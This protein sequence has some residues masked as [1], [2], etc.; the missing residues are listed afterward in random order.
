[1]FEELGTLEEDVLKRDIAVEHA[2]ST[3]VDENVQE[4][5][6]YHARERFIERPDVTESTEQ[7]SSTAKLSHAQGLVV[8]FVEVRHPHDARVPQRN[9]EPGF[10][11][12]F[13]LV[14]RSQTKSMRDC[15]EAL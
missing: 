3:Q 11:F 10:V 13:P 2:L 14:G 12:S 5:L 15:S 1:M 8:A 6:D 7:A 4:L 9:Q